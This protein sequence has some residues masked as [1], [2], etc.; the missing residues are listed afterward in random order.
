MDD[1]GMP[2]DADWMVSLNRRM[3]AGTD[4]NLGTDDDT[5]RKICMVVI[6]LLMVT[7]VPA[8]LVV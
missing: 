1:G 5:V 3:L 7:V 4:G 8:C 6:Q 2:I